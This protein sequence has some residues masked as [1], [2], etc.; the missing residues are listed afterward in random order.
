MKKAFRLKFP[1]LVASLAFL[2]A[3]LATSAAPALAA[4]A[5]NYH[6]Y[7]KLDTAA[8]YNCPYSG[9]HIYGQVGT[10]SFKSPYDYRNVEFYNEWVGDL[11]YER[12][13]QEAFTSALVYR[14]CINNDVYY[15][16]YGYQM[17]YRIQY[18]TLN[19]YSGGCS[20]SV[21]YSAWKYGW[22]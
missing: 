12:Y 6:L 5:P 16:Y 18:I 8:G 9:T 19:C 14:G 11:H 17:T 7:N 22:P 2:L 21:S 10:A 15:M 20:G 1:L 3:G 4:S 13:Y